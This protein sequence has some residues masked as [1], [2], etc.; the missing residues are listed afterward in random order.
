LHAALKSYD[1]T[2]IHIRTMH[3]AFH[4]LD[5]IHIPCKEKRHSWY[6]MFS[7]G[8]CNVRWGKEGH[9]AEMADPIIIQG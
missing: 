8:V 5:E 9:D 7:F 3:I 6:L 2:T 4:I 1:Y